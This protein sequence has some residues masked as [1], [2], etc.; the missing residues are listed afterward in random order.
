MTMRSAHLAPDHKGKAMEN[1]GTTF[2]IGTSVG[3]MV[4]TEKKGYRFLTIT[5]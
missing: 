4:E 3:T 1:L 5:P 2:S